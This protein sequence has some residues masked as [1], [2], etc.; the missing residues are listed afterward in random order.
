MGVA[1]DLWAARRQRGAT[2]SPTIGILSSPG[3]KGSICRFAERAAAE[4]SRLTPT[5]VMIQTRRSYRLSL[6]R[7]SRCG[8]KRLIAEPPQ[9]P[10]KPTG[11][12]GL[13]Q[14]RARTPAGAS[15]KARHSRS[16]ASSLMTRQ[17]E[18]N[19]GFSD[20]SVHH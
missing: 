13:R 18:L 7:L 6:V 10:E 11:I 2:T 12:Y 3:G 17:L 20:P 9:E 1:G 4:E 14:S 8:K 16:R 5:F 19:K 15:H